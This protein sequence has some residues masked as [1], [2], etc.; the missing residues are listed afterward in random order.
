MSISHSLHSLVFYWTFF[1]SLS[2]FLIPWKTH[3]LHL[4]AFHLGSNVWWET[5]QRGDE[6]LLLTTVLW[7][8]GHARGEAATLF[9]DEAEPRAPS[10]PTKHCCV[11]ES[12]A[13]SG[14]RNSF[15]SARMWRR[16]C[17][18]HVLLQQLAVTF[19][20]TQEACVHPQ[21]G[22]WGD[23]GPVLRTDLSR[24]HSRVV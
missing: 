18:A 22:A 24:H 4:Q 23:P 12:D 21:A 13:L 7:F 2:S 19:W 8:S 6:Q 1:W 11:S 14:G 9:R 3:P 20:L 10:T 16:D 15:P 17:W 5:T